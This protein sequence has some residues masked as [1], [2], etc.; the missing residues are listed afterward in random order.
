MPPV[1]LVG[2]EPNF[3][4]LGVCFIFFVMLAREI[5]GGLWCIR[6]RSPL[7]A[8]SAGVDSVGYPTESFLGCA[9]GL[10]DVL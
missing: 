3:V 5:C 10:Q 4:V 2:D 9:S 1:C 8:C 6:M 7:S